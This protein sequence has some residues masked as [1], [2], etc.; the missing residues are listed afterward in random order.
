MEG[1]G[2]VGGCHCCAGCEREQYHLRK[3]STHNL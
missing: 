1:D 2:T 3:R